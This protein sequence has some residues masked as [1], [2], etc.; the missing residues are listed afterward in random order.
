MYSKSKEMKQRKIKIIYKQPECRQISTGY[1]SKPRVNI[2][3]SGFVKLLQKG[4]IGCYESKL[5]S[6][7]SLG[8]SLRNKH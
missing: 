4:E 7:S 8:L 5:P 2:T 6:E 1:E 3:H